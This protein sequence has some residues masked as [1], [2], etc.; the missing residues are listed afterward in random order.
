MQS[1]YLIAR[2]DGAR[3]AIQ[4]DLVESVVHVH[5][6][7]PV[8]KSDPSV[9][10][11]FALRSRVLTLIDSQFSVTGMPR[12]VENRALAIIAEIAGHHFGLLVE[13][14]EDVVTID[15][16]KIEKSVAPS[17]KWYGLATGLVDI[18]GEIAMIIDPAHLVAGQKALAA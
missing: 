14:V 6:V 17:P 1:L 2:I 10:G 7:V 16:D 9:A 4:S 11:L 5:D 15:S 18:D 12:P 13:S 3:V 8:P